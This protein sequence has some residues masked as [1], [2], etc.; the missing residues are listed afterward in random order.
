MA[1]GLCHRPCRAKFKLH[2]IL[3]SYR[4][5]AKG[6]KIKN[7]YFITCT[8]AST[9][10]AIPPSRP[11]LERSFPPLVWQWRKGQ[12]QCRHVQPWQVAP[13]CISAVRPWAKSSALYMCTTRQFRQSTP[14]NNLRRPRQLRS[15]PSRTGCSLSPD[16]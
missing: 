16:R 4:Y 11:T 3:C 1:I 8:V 5:S 10:P 9:T 15:S 6:E 2:F 13:R 14:S 7:I 12:D